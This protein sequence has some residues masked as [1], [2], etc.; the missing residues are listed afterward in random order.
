IIYL[1]RYIGILRSDPLGSDHQVG[2]HGKVLFAQS[3]QFGVEKMHFY[4]NDREV[5]SGV[6]K[7]LS[8][9]FYEKYIFLPQ[10]MKI[11]NIRIAAHGYGGQGIAYISVR[12][13]DAL[14]I[15]EGIVEV[16]GHVEHTEHILASDVRETYFGEKDVWGAFQDRNKANCIHCVVINMKKVKTGSNI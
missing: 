10:G 9:P 16:K 5:A 6:Y 3:D 2:A 13:K 4:I 15:P 7:N 12:D 8:T 14:Y 11:K 1:C